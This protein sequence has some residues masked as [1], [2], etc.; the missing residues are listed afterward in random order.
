MADKILGWILSLIGLVI[1][2]VVIAAIVSVV[3]T[4]TGGPSTG[5]CVPDKP[6]ANNTIVKRGATRSSDLSKEWQTVWD[7]FSDSLDAGQ[8]KSI[9]Y[10]E[11]QAS[12]RADTYL[13]EK[14]AP[15]QHV[16]ICFHDGEG[17]AKANVNVPVLV[18]LP[19][20]GD[21]F[22]TNVGIRGTIDLSGP[23]PKITIRELDAG[24]LP[25]F[26]GDQLKGRIESIV[27][28]RL[29]DLTVKHKYGVI[30]REA[31]VEIDGAP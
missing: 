26:V 5:E 23:K 24:N 30:F 9:A 15:L 19:L 3:L 22:A 16:A 17:E 7:S 8:A 14:D 1:G 29:D 13:R 4:A 27:N 31:E 21:I 11:S 28:D 18:D 6:D 12:S 25:G 10:S 20:I 2:F